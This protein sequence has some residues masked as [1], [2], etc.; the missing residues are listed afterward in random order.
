MSLVGHEQRIG[1][2]SKDKILFRKIINFFEEEL[3]L[4]LLVSHERL[5]KLL[6]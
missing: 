4:P 1:F 6:T 3:T 2:L 5:K